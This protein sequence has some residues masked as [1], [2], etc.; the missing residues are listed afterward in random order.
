MAGDNEGRMNPF[1]FS[2]FK[3]HKEGNSTF[4]KS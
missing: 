3:L 4:D 1:T 2:D